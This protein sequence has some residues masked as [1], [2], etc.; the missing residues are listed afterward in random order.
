V[1]EIFD[2]VYAPGDLSRPEVLRVDGG[3]TGSDALMQAQADILGLP[4]ARHA[5]R[6]AT[7]VGAA[8]CAARGAGL[9]APS[10]T[11][12]FVRHDPPFEPRLSSDEATAKLGR[13]KLAVY[14]AN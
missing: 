14:G 9:L 1:R 4:V 3:L 12:G 8:V 11:A 2:H 5:L 6:E 7:V 10:E 13:W